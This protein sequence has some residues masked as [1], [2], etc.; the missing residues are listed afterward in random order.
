MWLL[1]DLGVIE[2]GGEEPL[3]FEILDGIVQ[4]PGQRTGAA[5]AE[6][7]GPPAEGTDKWNPETTRRNTIHQRGEKQRLQNQWAGD[8]MKYVWRDSP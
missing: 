1:S 2:D 8:G 3:G 4:Q 5:W 6:T 7:D